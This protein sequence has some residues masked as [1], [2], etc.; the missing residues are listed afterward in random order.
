MPTAPDETDNADPEVLA[1]RRAFGQRLKELRNEAE[2]TQ[3]Q[4]AEAA[5]INRVF[6]VGVE[7][8]RR[9]VSL[10]KVFALA[11]A[12]RVDVGRLFVNLGSPRAE[13]KPPVA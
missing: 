4:L 13:T 2:L 11:R 8:G 12:L 5:G 3:G 1:L 7:G 6:Y 9:N 10:D